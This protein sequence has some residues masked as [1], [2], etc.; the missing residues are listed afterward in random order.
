MM[1]TEVPTIKLINAATKEKISRVY[2]TGHTLA[3]QS[4]QRRNST[5]LKNLSVSTYEHDK[6]KCLHLHRAQEVQLL[7]KTG[8]LAF[9][10]FSY[11]TKNDLRGL[12]DMK[13]ELDVKTYEMKSA[14]IL[15]K[16]FIV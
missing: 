1:T 16:L 3:Q 8:R 6:E 9:S 12:V 10:Q 7:R 15:K 11:R 14:T 13:T 2:D 4:G 5:I